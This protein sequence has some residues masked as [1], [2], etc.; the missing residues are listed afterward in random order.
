MIGEVCNIANKKQRC[1]HGNTISGD[2][3]DLVFSNFV[4]VYVF[5]S[6]SFLEAKGVKTCN[7]F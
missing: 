1:Q 5:L 3:K 4:V 2:I 6:F 7:T